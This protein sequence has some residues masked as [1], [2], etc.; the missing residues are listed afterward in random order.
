M[1]QNKL[2]SKEI[3]RLIFLIIILSVVT[4]LLVA[5]F[6]LLL[7][8]VTEIRWNNL[9][10]I[11]FLP[12]AG[13]FITWLYSAWGKNASAG[14]DLIIDEIHEPGAG[15]PAR[16]TPLI[17]LTTIITHLFGGSAGREGTAVQMGG[18]L[19][20]F[21][22]RLFHIKEKQSLL[23]MCGIAAGFGAVFGTPFA[24][25]IFALE[26]LTIGQL[27]YKAI[28]PCLAASF[29]ADISC[30]YTGVLHT[31]YHISS[32][33]DASTYISIVSTDLVLFVKVI[34]AAA[35]FGYAGLLF[36]VACH[37]VKSQTNKRIK[38][39]WLRPV[40]GA[41]LVIGISYAL[42]SFDYLGLGVTNP[43]P[44]GVS[45]LSAFTP[46]GSG[47]LSWFWKL[48]LTAITIG[49]GFKGGEVTPLFFVG[50]T[51]GNVLA[52]I[53]GSPV[54]LFAAL[55]FIA[56]FAAATK[57]PLAC[58]IMGVELFG[59]ENIIFYAIACFTAYYCSGQVGIYKAQ[60][61]K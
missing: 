17:F 30:R 23:L 34:A 59:T 14:N 29:I 3:Y 24:G 19:A 8:I 36:S 1:L 2:V 42:G 22:S 10:I 41:V 6:L 37:Q 13:I 11:I 33:V 52:T 32:I 49:T 61:R 31:D 26:V 54:D 39:V 44:E 48:L 20:A 60:R 55:G 7:D 27:K 51:L 46:G 28:V 9:W 5:A 21:F 53:S 4:G 25:A 12:L 35:I 18:G 43:D 56:V 40:I 45:I 58:T 15:L 57:T 38:N 47:Y 16:L 50:A